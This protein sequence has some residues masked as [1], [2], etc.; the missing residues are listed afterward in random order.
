MVVYIFTRLN[1][2]VVIKA[3][4]IKQGKKEFNSPRNRREKGTK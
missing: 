3:T 4:W 1:N 2:K